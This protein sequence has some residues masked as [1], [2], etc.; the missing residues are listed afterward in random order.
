MKPWKIALGLAA[1]CA[2]CC[3]IPAL[4]LAGG[5]AALG[6]GL[7]ACAGELL[8]AAAVLCTATLAAA[9]WWWRRRAARSAAACGCSTACSREG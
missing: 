7:L 3:A 5:L 9:A 1:A 8:P 2:A 4:G 6:S